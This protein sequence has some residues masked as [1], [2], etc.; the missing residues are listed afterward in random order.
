MS[1]SQDPWQGA[2]SASP[3]GNCTWEISQDLQ[4]S[5]TENLGSWSQ[6]NYPIDFVCQNYGQWRGFPINL[7]HCYW[8]SWCQQ[9][10]PAFA[11]EHTL[12]PK[13]SHK[14]PL[15]LLCAQLL[16][17]MGVRFLKWG[18]Q[19]LLPLSL[20]TN[21]LKHISECAYKNRHHMSWEQKQFL[22]FPIK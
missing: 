19:F 4:G 3:T 9:K 10:L 17:K 18:L 1:S 5:A 21:R 22:R 16:W 15:V 2:R 20:Y 14:S 11:P 13:L 12:G 7:V 6:E 8:V